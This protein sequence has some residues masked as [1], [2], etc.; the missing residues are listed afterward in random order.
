MVEAQ[1][2]FTLLML[3]HLQLY[4]TAGDWSFYVK[5][6]A[7]KFLI[8]MLVWNKQTFVKYTIH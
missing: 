1:E 2:T 5:E 6:L 3:N 7:S 8:A 4:H